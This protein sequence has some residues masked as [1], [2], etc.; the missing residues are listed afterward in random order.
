MPRW[1][2]QRLE[3][4]GWGGVGRCCVSVRIFCLVVEHCLLN[5][6]EGLGD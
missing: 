3:E 2:W 1:Q 4:S 5:C 6:G